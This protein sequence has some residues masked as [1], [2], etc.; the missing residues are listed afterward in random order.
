[1]YEDEIEE[2]APWNLNIEQDTLLD[3]SIE[4]EQI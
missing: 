2:H 3:E 4:D 1:M